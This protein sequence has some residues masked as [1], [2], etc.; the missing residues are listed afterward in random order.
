M[1][2]EIIAVIGSQ[3]KTGARVLKKLED[4]GDLSPKFKTMT[5]MRFPIK[6]SEWRSQNEKTFYRRTDYSSNQAA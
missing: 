3:G 5:L 4:S 6:L 2:Q 1:K